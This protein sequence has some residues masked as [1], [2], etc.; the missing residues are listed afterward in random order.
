MKDW[1]KLETQ[2]QKKIISAKDGLRKKSKKRKKNL[3]RKKAERKKYKEIRKTPKIK[4]K[5]EEKN[6]RYKKWRELIVNK[7]WIEEK[8][9]ICRNRKK[10][11]LKKKN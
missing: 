3:P 10:V 8:G 6:N 7:N 2:Q 9:V 4:Q 5:Q 1:K 11:D